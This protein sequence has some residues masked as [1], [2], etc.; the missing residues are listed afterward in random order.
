MPEQLG[1]LQRASLT[2]R[3]IE[4]A[5]IEAMPEQ[6]A[7]WLWKMHRHRVGGPQK[8]ALRTK[9]RRGSGMARVVIYEYDVTDALRAG[10]RRKSTAQ[11]ATVGL[12]IAAVLT[13][14]VFVLMV[15]R[16]AMLDPGSGVG[17]W[18]R[19]LWV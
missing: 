7:I 1:A 15:S 14:A 4:L 18:A 17:K 12:L 2:G 11:G 13:V 6:H 10:I 9:L 3:R 8:A 19:P 5:E 16:M